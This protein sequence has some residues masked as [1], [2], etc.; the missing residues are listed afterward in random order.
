MALIIIGDVLA[1]AK[2]NRSEL[3]NPYFTTGYREA[4]KRPPGIY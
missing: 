2:Y 1:P 4:V 3:Y